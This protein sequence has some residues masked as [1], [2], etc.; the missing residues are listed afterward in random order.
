M[1]TIKFTLG[2]FYNGA[3]E[4]KENYPDS[5]YVQSLLALCLHNDE[6]RAGFIEYCKTLCSNEAVTALKSIMSGYANQIRD[7]IPYHIERWQGTINRDYT[8]KIW[9]RNTKSMEKWAG[10]RPAN[11]LSYL[12][13]INEYFK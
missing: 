10:K 6:F 1:D 13:Q 5:L 9:K 3:Y 2:N 11:F 4:M 7:E 8:A 12:E